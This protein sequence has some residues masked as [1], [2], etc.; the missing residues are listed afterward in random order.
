M[1]SEVTLIILKARKYV[2]AQCQMD[3]VLLRASLYLESVAEGDSMSNMESFSKQVL[4]EP[5]ILEL[6][7]WL[8]AEF[9]QTWDLDEEGGM[10]GIIDRASK[11]SNS[12]TSFLIFTDSKSISG[13]SGITSILAVNSKPPSSKNLKTTI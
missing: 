4:S 1:Q 8:R 11:Y 7:S 10:V 6:C 9:Y 2:I 5:E 3:I 12:E 13:I